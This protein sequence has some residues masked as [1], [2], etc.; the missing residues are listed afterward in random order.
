MKDLMMSQMGFWVAFSI[1]FMI[2]GL[3]WFAVKMIKLSKEKPTPL[4]YDDDK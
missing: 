1:I 2:V 4:S 3:W